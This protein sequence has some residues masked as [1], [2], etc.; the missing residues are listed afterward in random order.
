MPTTKP[1]PLAWQAPLA[2]WMT[3]EMKVAQLEALA[4]LREPFPEESINKLP[5]GVAKEG[6]KKH[7]DECGGYHRQ[8]R[9]HL[10]YVGH[11]YVTE[12]LLEVDPL[13][14]WEPAAS[15]AS[16]SPA[17]EW[18]KDGSPV[19][20]WIKLTVAGM[21]RYGYGS[22]TAGKSE[23][24]KELIGDAIRNAAMRFGCALEYWKKDKGYTED[25]EPTRRR[26]TTSGGAAARP[27]WLPAD[28]KVGRALGAARKIQE[29][30]TSLLEVTE[31]N[32]PAV[33]E[34]L[35]GST[36]PEPEAGDDIDPAASI[37]SITGAEREPGDWSTPAPEP[38][39][40]DTKGRT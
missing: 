8:A 30:I 7:C 23:A 12:R 33:L 16:G 26:A 6:D 25:D 29:G 14:D 34:R 13:W 36:Q 10:D 1:K 2:D 24:V 32:V 18:E 22:V 40:V 39:M 20:L 21:T 19:G 27:E 4:K 15:D 9:M 11:A 35:A 37:A 38:E 3:D 28:I 17:V 31:E 5:Q